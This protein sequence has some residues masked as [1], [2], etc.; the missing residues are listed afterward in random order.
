M[1]YTLNYD[2]GFRPMILALREFKAAA[3]KMVSRPPV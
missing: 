2:K 1:K 3:E